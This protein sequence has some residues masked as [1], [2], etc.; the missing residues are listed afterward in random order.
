M[1]AEP[2]ISTDALYVER[3]TDLRDASNREVRQHTTAATMLK[4]G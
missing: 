2:Q 3:D 4:W 1:P